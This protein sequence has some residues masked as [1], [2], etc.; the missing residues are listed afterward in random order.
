VELT[1]SYLLKASTLLLHPGCVP[2][3]GS[4]RRCI[5]RGMK[6]V[7]EKEDQKRMSFGGEAGDG[8]ESGG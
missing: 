1:L 3:S 6:G 7:S 2:S 4:G 8:V 5:D